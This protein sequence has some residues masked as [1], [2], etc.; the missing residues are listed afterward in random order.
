MSQKRVKT[1]RIVSVSGSGGATG[2]ASI[3]I[4]E[5]IVKH[6]KFIL[7]VVL[8]SVL[9]YINMLNGDFVSDD[10]GSITD[11]PNVGNFKVMVASGNSMYISNYIIVK[12]FG[13]GSPFVYHVVSLFFYAVLLALVYVFLYKMTN[14]PMISKVATLLFCLHPIHSECV[15][16]IS[17]RI[18]IILAIYTLSAILV[19]MK[20]FESD[21]LKYILYTNLF[22]VL[23]F[24]TDKPRAFSIWILILLYV[25]FQGKKRKLNITKLLI[26]EF[27]ALAPLFIFSLSSILSRV[28]NVN[29]GYNGDGSLV[30]NPIL[31]YPL[32][33][34][35]YL[36]LLF[37][38]IDLT[39]YHTM[40]VFPG[41]LNVGITLSYL[42]LLIYYLVKKNKLAFF[43]LAF[44][45]L[46]TAP[47]M[48]PI[49]VAW[50]NAERYIFLGSLGYCIFL[51]YLYTKI[52]FNLKI[53]KPFILISILILYFLRIFN[54]NIDWSTNHLLW[55]NTVQ[56]SPNS[57]NAW[58]N[59]GDDY[60]KQNDYPNAVKGFSMSIAYKN[61]Y[62]D[63]YHNRGNVFIKMNRLD[64]AR[65]DYMTALKISPSIF[66]SSF[67]LAHISFV[68]KNYLDSLTHL[69]NVLAYQIMPQAVNMKISA[70][71]LLGRFDDAKKTLD[72]YK[73][74]MLPKTFQKIYD[75]IEKSRKVGLT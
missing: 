38:P 49:K 75:E 40:Y 70:L 63:A 48:A 18:Y 6:W 50:L 68:E 57:H 39:L 46:A 67:A 51:S 55:V 37:F 56:V 26:V 34:S 27:I 64:L 28:D 74:M 35:K 54:R 65:E 43:G 72:L 1:N 62:A 19:F 53:L 41:W 30:Y 9:A 17:G 71:T 14:R 4:K 24:L 36:Q 58:N 66:H 5:I 23:A 8:I 32:S 15:S 60:D 25:W 11:N 10:Y 31:Q 33:M 42:A 22:F 20:Y 2:E 47:S 44:I 45:F 59:I 61:N 21:K 73:S 7:L 29:S 69:E 16:W 52:S 3:G 13:T 12:L